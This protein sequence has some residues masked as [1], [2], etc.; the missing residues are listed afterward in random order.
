MNLTKRNYFKNSVN[1]IYIKVKNPYIN[2][3]AEKLKN[4]I[5]GYL[6]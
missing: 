5:Y 6:N 2:L 4:L 3:T 1:K